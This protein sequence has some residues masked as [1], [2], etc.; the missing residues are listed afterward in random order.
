MPL[1]LLLLWLFIAGSLPDLTGQAQ[2]LAI[3]A[4][5][6]EPAVFFAELS[7]QSGINIIFSDNIIEQLQPIT[8]EIKGVTLDETLEAVLRN[9]RIGYRRVDEQIVLF[10]KEPLVRYTV[11]GLVTDSVSGEPLISAYVVDLI[12]GTTT[13]TN[14]YGYFNLRLP[15]GPVKLVCGYLGYASQTQLMHLQSNRIIQLELFPTSVLKEIIVK[16]YPEGIHGLVTVPKAERVTLADLQHAVHLGGASDIYRA[17]DLIPGVHTGTDGIGGIHVRGGANDQNL[18]LMDGVPVYHPNHLLGIVSVF[19]YQVLQQAT[20]YKSNFPSRFSGRLSSVMDVRTREGNIHQWGMSGN[21]SVSEFGLTMEGPIVRDKMAVLLSW[22]YF[23]PGLFMDNITQRWKRRNGV[24]GFA[25]LDYFDFNGK[26][27]WRIGDRDR[28]YL[29]T[30]MGRDYFTEETTNRRDEIDR[31]TGQRIVTYEFFDKKL[32]WN[33]R[34]A[35]LRWNHILSDHIFS[36]FILSTSRFRLQSVDRTEFTFSFPGSGDEPTS[37]FDAKEFKSGIEDITMRLELDIRPVHDHVFT[38]GLYG[39]RYQFKP[40]SITINEESKVGEFYLDEGLLD[41][42]YFANFQIRALEAGAYFE[43]QWEIDPKWRLTSGIHVSSFLVQKAHYLDPQLRLS[44]DYLATPELAF[45][46]GYGRMVQYLHQLTSSSI[47]LPTDLWVPTTRQVAPALS[48]QYSVSAIWKPEDAFSLEASAYMKDMRHVISY[49][50]GASFLLREGLLPSSIVDAANW[51]AKITTGMGEASGVELQAD[52]KGRSWEVQ[53][54]G[55]WSRSF[56]HFEEINQG[57]PFPDR[58]DR[59]WS[60]SL[61]GSFK[62]NQKWSIQAQWLFSTGG[63]ITLAESKF[64]NPGVF[65]PQIGIN[66]SARNGFRLPDYH[67]LDVSLHYTF[68][69]GQDFYHALSLNLYNVYNRVNPFY[70]TLTEDPIT[71]EFA[72]KQFSLFRF[73]PSLSYR[74]AFN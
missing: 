30:Y 9:S 34:T 61:A 2:L 39:I 4:E 7:L 10:E 3:R 41:D 18:I 64:F 20:I 65:F 28:L 57:K 33:N 29:S 14:N 48:D 72:F 66:Y 35:V 19:N 59:R 58:Y 8:L 60:T 55:A 42:V 51:E 12:S 1:R 36:N 53:A 25:D 37:G 31:E 45:N 63:A 23:L 49:Q 11:S 73:F 24:E 43:D 38:A 22:R 68:D 21:V 71:Q 54:S 67:R 15:A 27:N 56:R 69:K 70:I 74:F 52:Y 5:R 17:A 62:L 47:G 44:L 46:A 50:E 6:R 40:K 16:A 32:N 13:T 26:L